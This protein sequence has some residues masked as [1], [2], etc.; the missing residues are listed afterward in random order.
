LNSIDDGY[1]ALRRRLQLEQAWPLSP[2]WSAA[3]DFLDLLADHCLQENPK[4]IVECSSGLTTLVLAR[5]CQINGTGRVWSLENGP[6]YAQRTRRA[7]RFYGLDQ[8]ASVIDAP[9]SS[10]TLPRGIFQWYA[11]GGLPDRSIDMLVVDGP[12][13]FIQPH[14]RYPALPLLGKKLA[15]GCHV[16]LDD[17]ARDD[18]QELAGWWRDENPGLDVRYIDNERGCL[19]ARLLSATENTE[20]TEE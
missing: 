6:E 3:A 14:S 18:E 16:F 7:L 5:C 11:I 4:C 19:V 8:Y 10:V 1:A 12:P 17:A 15:A 13:G 20:D 2:N 9:L